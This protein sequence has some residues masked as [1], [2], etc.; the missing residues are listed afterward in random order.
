MSL[1]LHSQVLE[2]REIEKKISQEY[3]SGLIRCPV[4]LSIGQ[5]ASAVGVIA[6]L[7]RKDHLYSTH[8]SHAHYIAKGGSVKAMIAEIYGKHNG[9][10]GGVGGSM[11]LQDIKVNFHGSIP[12]VGSSIGLAAGCAYH[13]KMQKS[14]DLTV[15]FIGDASLEEGIFFEICNFA[16][17]HNLKLLF[18]C[19]NNLFSVYTDLQKRQ[20]TSNFT[21]Y[22]DAFNIK[23]LKTNGNNVV[24]IYNQ[25]KK[26]IN[27]IHKY[28]KPF[29][30]QLDTFRYYEH[31]GPNI[32]DHLNYRNKSLVYKWKKLDPVISA[33]S[34]I[35]KNYGQK[36]LQNLKKTINKNLEKYFRLAIDSKLPNFREASKHVYS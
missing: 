14:N 27:Y 9:C 18:V 11:H 7:S 29:F 22:A 15:V 5:E 2:I 34:F 6:C 32:D 12:I 16:S 8:R 13:N 33:E 24:E 21:K 23:S 30:L 35:I 20:S 19:E 25:T 36:K 17:L 26:I 3:P 28:N 1:K 4:H 10:V 31:C